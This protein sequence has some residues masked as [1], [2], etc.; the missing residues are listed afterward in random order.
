MELPISHLLLTSIIEN[1]PQNS[2]VCKVGILYFV[3]QVILSFLVY[4]L[5]KM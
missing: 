4:L 3:F 5:N 2:E 1:N